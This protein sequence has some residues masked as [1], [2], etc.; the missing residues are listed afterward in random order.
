MIDKQTAHRNLVLALKLTLL[1]LL[2]FAATLAIGVI[3][4][5]G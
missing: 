1:S 2:I 3:V 5:Y 4:R